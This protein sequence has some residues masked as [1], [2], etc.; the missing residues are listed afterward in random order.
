ML[1]QTA[2]RVKARK[3]RGCRA[4]PVSERPAE[5]RPRKWRKILESPDLIRKK[6]RCK[7]G[8]RRT[9]FRRKAGALETPRGLLTRCVEPDARALTDPLR[10]LQR[11]NDACPT[12]GLYADHASLG[13]GNRE[14]CIDPGGKLHQLGT[15][16]GL[17]TA[18]DGARAG[19][20]D[21]RGARS[22]R[23]GAGLKRSGGRRRRRQT[24]STS[25]GGPLRRCPPYPGCCSS[26]AT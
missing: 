2:A 9:L 8:W 25:R 15:G 22:G 10:R 5:S 7:G 17:R 3:R 14:L 13:N 24:P 4:K 12:R 20:C 19:S 18:S 6:R 23:R 1:V 21:T 11:Q 26:G 16:T